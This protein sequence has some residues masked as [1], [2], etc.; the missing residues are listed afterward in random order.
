MSVIKLKFDSNTKNR[1]TTKKK[2][3]AA[4]YKEAVKTMRKYRTGF[5]TKNGF[6]LRGTLNA[7]QKQK[8]T[9]AYKNIIVMSENQTVV[10]VRR[11][12][13]ESE[14]AYNRRLRDLKTANGQDPDSPFKGL[15]TQGTQDEDKKE[16]T[17]D[18]ILIVTKAHTDE[19]RVIV[20][21]QLG[22]TEDNQD[23]IDDILEPAIERGEEILNS[24]G[25]QLIYTQTVCGN[26]AAMNSADSSMG[27]AEQIA[28]AASKYPEKK[29]EQFLTIING[30]L[31]VGERI[32]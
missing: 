17:K 2:K 8:I 27:L 21:V 18:G 28:F 31:C 19:M 13:K 29:K 14:S 6:N 30:V 23:I 4:F 16:Y 20:P 1:Y 10:K 25:Y 15:I 32:F 12:P 24:K 26:K 11:K 7:A 5:D 22:I 3:S 9:K